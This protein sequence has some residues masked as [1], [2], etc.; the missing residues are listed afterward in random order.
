MFLGSLIENVVRKDVACGRDHGGDVSAASV[1]RIN[2]LTN[3]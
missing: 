2:S 1:R 3:S